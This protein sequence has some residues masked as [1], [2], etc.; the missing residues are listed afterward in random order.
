[1]FP[2]MA[3]D[4]P[5]VPC[6]ISDL[7]LCMIGIVPITIGHENGTIRLHQQQHQ[8]L[9]THRFF[10]TSRIIYK[11]YHPTSKT[12]PL[13]TTRSLASGR[14]ASPLSP[15]NHVCPRIIY[16]CVFVAGVLRGERER[17]IRVQLAPN[18]NV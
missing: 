15:H 13:A 17:A 14:F 16:V 6:P 3:D 5:R 9:A 10:T 7:G 18:R 11:Q 8:S 1:M 2:R 12:Y 4:T